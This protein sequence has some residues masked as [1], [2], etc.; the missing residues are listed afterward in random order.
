MYPVDL[1]KVR[2]ACQLPGI[3]TDSL[4][5]Q[6]ANNQSIARRNLH[7]TLQRIRNNY[8]D[9]GRTIALA[10]YDQ[11][12]RGSRYGWQFAASIRMKTKCGNRPSARGLFCNIRSR[13]AGYGGK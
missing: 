4:T 12:Y 9:R 1:L 5:D 7:W 3:S 2:L 13:E 11:R 10:W 6:D 8:S